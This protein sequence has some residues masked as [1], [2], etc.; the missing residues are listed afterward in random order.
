[1]RYCNGFLIYDWL[2]PQLNLLR[3]VHAAFYKVVLGKCIDFLEFL[4]DYSEFRLNCCRDIYGKL[5]ILLRERVSY[6]R[7][8]AF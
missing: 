4:N 3:I 8:I 5:F 2:N 6:V 1:M 7:T